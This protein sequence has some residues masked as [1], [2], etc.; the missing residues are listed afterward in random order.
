MKNEI[1]YVVLSDND[2]C[3]PQNINIFKTEDEALIFIMENPHKY[4]ETVEVG[5]KGI[6]S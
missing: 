3:P 4:I 6:V 2:C 5:E 1:V